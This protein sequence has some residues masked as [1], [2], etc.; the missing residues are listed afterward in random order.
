M[1]KYPRSSHLNRTSYFFLNKAQTTKN[2]S[3]GPENWQEPTQSFGNREYFMNKQLCSAAHM[4]LEL[5]LTYANEKGL[6]KSAV[7][8]HQ[9]ELRS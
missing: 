1:R 3:A 8:D 5:H 9:L 4:L 7:L 2:F 6:I